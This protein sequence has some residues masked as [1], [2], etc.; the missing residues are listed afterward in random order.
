[1]STSRIISAP[2]EMLLG[3]GY[4]DTNACIVRGLVGALH[5]A[6]G[7]PR[8]MTAA[9]LGCETV[10]GRSRPSWLQTREQLPRL[11]DALVE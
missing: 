3:G 7:I 2:H 6:A 1:M 5:G 8:V 4:T 11:L 9:V 10:K